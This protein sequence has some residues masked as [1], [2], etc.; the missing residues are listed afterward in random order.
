MPN[1]TLR[2][3]GLAALLTLSAQAGMAQS[4][5]AYTALTGAV[6]GYYP[7]YLPKPLFIDNTGKVFAHKRQYN[8]LLHWLTLQNGYGSALGVG[9]H[10]RAASW[11]AGKQAAVN[12]GFLL[13]PTVSYTM[14]A[15][16]SNGTYQVVLN[17]PITV[18][19]PPSTTMGLIK[20][21]IFGK[22]PNPASER[23]EAFGVND[24]GWVVGLSQPS[25]GGSKAT[26][27]RDGQAIYQKAPSWDSAVARDI[28][29]QGVI[30]GQV[31]GAFVDAAGNYYQTQHA[32]HWSNGALD[33][34]LP[35]T[36]LTRSDAVGISESGQVLIRYFDDYY[37]PSA[38]AVWADGVLTPLSPGKQVKVFDINASGVVAGQVG[39]RAVIWKNGVEIDLTELAVSKGAKLP[40]GVVLAEALRIN[41]AGSVLVSYR[42]TADPYGYYFGRLNATP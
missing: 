7:D 39:E 20:N 13:L 22:L 35:E 38:G 29:N 31:R 26:L 28:N 25:S 8:L 12:G 41:D 33:W 34:V 18:N 32:A 9:N 37:Q 5:Y 24:K 14:Q 23:Q 15:A 1:P 3:I 27:W 19:L 10:P 42:T 21:G 40:A 30:V 36:P 2:T 16:S 4:A 11:A 17:A 6:G